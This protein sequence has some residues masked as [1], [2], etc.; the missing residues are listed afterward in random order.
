MQR[1]IFAFT[2]SFIAGVGLG[3][4]FRLDRSYA[5]I[6]YV[7]A[8]VFGAVALG[9]F[10]AGKRAKRRIPFFVVLLAFVLAG[11]PLGFARYTQTW[12]P[13]EFDPNAKAQHISAILGKFPD[14]DRFHDRTR[15]IGTIVAEPEYRPAKGKPGVVALLIEPYQVIPDPEKGEKYAVNGGN[16]MVLLR[17][18]R[19]FGKRDQE[20]GSVFAELADPESYGD[21]VVVD[22]AFLEFRPADNP[23]LF[24]AQDFYNDQDVY[25]TA[26]IYFWDKKNP[27]IEIV[28][29]RKGNPIVALAL[30]I[31]KRM[32]GVIKLT[33]PFPE[34]AF[35]AGVTLGARRGLTGVKCI[36]EEGPEETATTKSEDEEPDLRKLILDEF[37]WSGTSHVLAV[38]GLHVT[39]IA[40]ALWGF[41]VLLRIPRKIYAPMIVFALVIFCLITGARPSTVRAVIMNSLVILTYVY[42]GSGLRA[43]ILLAI[44][45]S[46]FAILMQNPRWLVAP[47]FALSFMAVLSL[48]LLTGPLDR[49]FRFIPGYSRLPVWLAQ[50]TAAQAAIQFGMMW[51]LSSYYFSRVSI[52]GPF[53]NFIAIPLIGIIVQLG[54][55]ACLLGLIP[56]IGLYLALPL[57]AA[58]YLMIYLFLWAAHI[59]TV[60]LPFPYVPSLTPRMVAGYYF[61]LSFFVFWKPLSRHF[62][63]LYYDL[64]MGIGGVRR[65]V[66]SLSLFTAAMLFTAA[67]IVLCFHPEKPD[68]KLHVEFLSVRFGSAVHVQTPSGG[69]LLFDAGP[70]DYRS[71]WNTG[72]RT[73]VQYLLKKRI[74]TLDAVVMTNTSP[75]DMGGLAA[76]VSILPAKRFYA[77]KNVWD[78]D[79]NDAAGFQKTLE[80]ELRNEAAENPRNKDFGAALFHFSKLATALRAPWNLRRYLEVLLIAPNRLFSLSGPPKPYLVREGTVLWREEGPG[81]TLEIVAIHPPEGFSPKFSNDESL[82]FSIR[83]GN[84]GF[85]LTSDLTKQG[86]LKLVEVDPRWLHSDVLQVPAHGSPQAAIP[87]LYK[88]VFGEK[89]GRNALA[90]V[91]TGWASDLKKPRRGHFTHRDSFLRHRQLFQKQLAAGI[92][93]TIEEL[94][95]RG[96]GIGR[97]D[98]NGAILVTS[99]GSTINVA[100]TIGRIG[101]GERFDETEGV[102]ELERQREF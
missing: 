101:R 62:R 99:D 46:A 24:N 37:R 18:S 36:F 47:A 21:V 63:I 14:Q 11:A 30:S 25:A 6:A 42:L 45:V 3:M 64:V 34:S 13:P 65:R 100:A 10:L 38:S 93:E 80:T 78:W 94:K 58:N 22:A 39:I 56:G 2:Y 61:L 32:L 90:V 28:S 67:I 5:W 7:L 73:I 84:T 98:E 60:V 4:G 97:T 16:V 27:P 1:I 49:L 71:G 17:P 77:G 23:G 9:L 44:G 85:L 102:S 51:P 72:E 91:S 33:V 81:G 57:N 48:A 55:F 79:P 68:G 31:K 50:F 43:S 59:S 41:F 52:A 82:A 75:E 74:N 12:Q 86:I 87:Y 29:R 26:S 89:A 66:F 40:G 70:N 92:E 35:L 69:H 53:A 20:F 95:G 83:Y 15:L 88:V 76:V 96:V 8:A 54:L 19:F